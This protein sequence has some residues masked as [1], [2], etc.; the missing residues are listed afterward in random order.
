[1]KKL[2]AS[3]GGV[4]LSF[5]LVSSA[6]AAT[7]QDDSSKVNKQL[8]QV[9]QATEKYHDVNVA[10]QDGYINTH[11]VAVSPEGVM[12]IHFVNPGLMFDGGVLNPNQ[13]EVL[14]YIPQ[15]NGG[16]KLVGVEY[17]VP[18]F[19]ANGH[20]SLFNHPFDGSMLNHDLDPANLTEEEIQNP[21]NRHYD[22]HVWL[23][24]ANPSGIFAPWNPA[25]KMQE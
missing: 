15:K 3:I 5:G 20:P 8:A 18:G 22:L 9:R 10:I 21:L 4:I 23:W 25:I 13:P 11:E 14:L 17:Y 12:G 2:I 24:H 16:Y 6:F 1:M 7:D 19:M